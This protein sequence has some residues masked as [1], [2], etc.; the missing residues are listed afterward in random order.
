MIHICAGYSA[1]PMAYPEEH[2]TK[3]GTKITVQTASGE[4]L[5]QF[6]SRSVLHWTLSHTGRLGVC[7]LHQSGHTVVFDPEGSWIADKT[8]TRERESFGILRRHRA[9]WLDLLRTHEP[10]ET[11]A[12]LPLRRED[13]VGTPLVAE[14]RWEQNESIER[15]HTQQRPQ[16][17]WI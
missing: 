13:A 9:S 17:S 5:E 1:R 4:R 7:Q 12:V 2:G 8:P 3:P 14:D 10:S 16:L 15:K 11:D 6:G